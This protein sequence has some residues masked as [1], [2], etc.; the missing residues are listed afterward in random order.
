MNGSF[1]E[2]NDPFMSKGC[3]PSSPRSYDAPVMKARAVT[4]VLAIAL[5]LSPAL[6]LAAPPTAPPPTQ[7]E[8]SARAVELYEESARAYKAGEFDEA[9]RLV[10]EAYTLSP[11]P[12]LLYNLARAHEKGG[13]VEEALREYRQYLSAEPESSDRGYIEKTIATLQ[14]QLDVTLAAREGQ[15]RAE[16]A[17]R[18]RRAAALV[19][20]GVGVLTLGAGV[21]LGVVATGRHSD[22][23]SPT[24]SGKD[25][26]ADESSAQTFATAANVCF[27]GGGVLVAGGLLWALLDRRAAA[28]GSNQGL[29]VT[30]TVGGLVMSGHF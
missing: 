23:A 12:V 6:A 22:A 26:V 10:F 28:P 1:V 14:Q 5:A 11:R 16:Q 17:S 8:S 30:P 15:A 9:A 2:V 29:V 18:S 7:E 27:V 20:A 25:A 4:S 3:H 13:H 21:T 24:T 19:T